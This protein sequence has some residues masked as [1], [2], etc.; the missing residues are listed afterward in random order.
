VGLAALTIPSKMIFDVQ[1]S[2]SCKEEH[3]FL[4]NLENYSCRECE[5]DSRFFPKKTD[6]IP[7]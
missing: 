3:E 7:A 1:I 6:L 2:A 5:V 4:R